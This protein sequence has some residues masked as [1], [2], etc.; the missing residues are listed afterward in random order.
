[1]MKIPVKY[2][3]EGLHPSES[4]VEIITRDGNEKLEVPNNSIDR[5]EIVIGWPVGQEGNYYLVELPR[6]TFRGSWRVW[7]SKSSVVEERSEVGAA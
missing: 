7:I 5:N 4:V 1:M 6:E 2:I 3:G